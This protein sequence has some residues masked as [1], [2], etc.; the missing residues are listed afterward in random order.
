M[1]WLCC[2]M[3]LYFKHFN[4]WIVFQCI[5]IPHLFTYSSIHGLIS[6]FFSFFFLA[7][8]DNAAV[9]ICM[10][11]FVNMYFQFSWVYKSRIAWSYGLVLKWLPH[12]IFPPT[13]Y[14]S[15]NF[16][17]SLSTLFIWHFKNYNHLRCEVVSCWGFDLHFPNDW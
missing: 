13:I 5:D 15:F 3:C 6:L 7:A 16:S 17:T 9:N 14:E 1:V 10:W 8:L 12:F 2:C 11:V 4:G